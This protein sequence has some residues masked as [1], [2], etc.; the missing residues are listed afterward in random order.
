VAP[1]QKVPTTR[2]THEVSICTGASR[3]AAL[4]ST[5]WNAVQSAKSLGK[6][7]E[8]GQ[9]SGGSLLITSYA[10]TKTAALSMR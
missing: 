6:G 5:G 3:D 8:Y 1:S 7:R 2:F 4:K 10:T 9:A